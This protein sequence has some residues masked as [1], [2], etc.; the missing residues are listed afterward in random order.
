MANL[1]IR[2][3]FNPGR[4]GS[5]MDKLGEFA[6]QTE[7]FLRSLSADLGVD[8]QK[9]KWLARNFT[10]ESVAFD[11]EYSDSVD[12]NAALKAESALRAL[13]GDSPIEACNVGLVGYGTLSEFAKIGKVLDADEV[14]YL[15][16]YCNDDDPEWQTVSHKKTS[17]IR[18]LLETPVITQGSIQG[19]I[20]SW[21]F[22]SNPSF[23]YLREFITGNL[24]KCE[25]DSHQYDLVHQATE[26]LKT[27]VHVYGSVEWDITSDAINKVSVNDIETT[28]PLSD[29]EFHKIFGG[30]PAYTGDL[31]TDEYISW[32]RDDE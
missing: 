27:T 31:S 13:S 32:L 24:V 3:R 26:T 29:I 9:G 23:F 2:L 10:N 1:R 16:L 15:G 30:A 20:H 6:T 7:R 14:F 18:Q 28:E 5:P 4:L 25:Y 8:A 17:E 22:G 19:V 12:D 21:S 11:G